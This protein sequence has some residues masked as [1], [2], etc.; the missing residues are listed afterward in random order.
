MSGSEDATP[1]NTSS[2][3]AVTAHFLPRS[4][5]YSHINKL[6]DLNCSH[7][8]FH[9]SLIY[10]HP[11]SF[12]TLTLITRLPYIPR[13]F[14]TI[15]PLFL[16]LRLPPSRPLTPPP[17]LSSISLNFPRDVFFLHRKRRPATPPSIFHRRP[18]PL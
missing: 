7:L 5:F 3:A 18:E 11:L 1:I 10:Y 4:L 6:M 15:A 16:F 2:C 14:S 13:H 12:A 17:R 9:F 8:F